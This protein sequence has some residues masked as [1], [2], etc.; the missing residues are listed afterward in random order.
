MV[1]K[2]V[3][4]GHKD[5]KVRTVMYHRF[6]TDA[7][8]RLLWLEFCQLEESNVDRYKCI[9]SDHFKKED[10][11]DYSIVNGRKVLRR[12]SF[13][14]VHAKRIYKGVVSNQGSNAQYNLYNICQKQCK[15]FIKEGEDI[16]EM[17][18]DENIVN[19]PNIN[20]ESIF[21]P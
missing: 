12:G 13:P 9:C 21:E 18:Y 2:C 17:F 20:G 10:Y 5:N 1:R 3:V 19:I 4:C 14:S 6:P 7:A 11:D 8:V 16:N 15:V